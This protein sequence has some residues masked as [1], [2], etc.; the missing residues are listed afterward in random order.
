MLIKGC[1]K[2]VIVMKETGNEM[3]EEAFFIL[4]PGGEKGLVSHEDVLEYANGIL[5]HSSEDKCFSRLPM[6]ARKKRGGY[7][8]YFFMGT[9]LG[10]LLSAGVL[11][12]I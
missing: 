6:L 11:F 2:R 7:F 3:I 4:R 10:A 5:S 1:N 12:L 8:A 9:I